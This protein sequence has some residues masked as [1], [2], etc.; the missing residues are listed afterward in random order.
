MLVIGV[1]FYNNNEG[2]QCLYLG[3][4]L[5]KRRQDDVK[6]VFGFIWQYLES[7]LS[8][9]IIYLP[10]GDTTYSGQVWKYMSWHVLWY[11]VES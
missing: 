3:L 10:P 7:N 1:F 4:R 8:V 5:S 11:V 6:L 9:L 2:E